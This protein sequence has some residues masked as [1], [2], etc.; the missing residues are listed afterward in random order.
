MND[1][2]TETD[3]VKKIVNQGNGELIDMKFCEIFDEYVSKNYP[4]TYYKI[5]WEKVKGNYKIFSWSH[6]DDVETEAFLKTTCIHNYDEICIIYGADEPALLVKREFAYKNLPNLTIFGWT[7]RYIV[8]VKRNQYGLIEIVPS[9]F[10]EVDFG[11]WL[12]ASC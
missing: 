1:F 4:W 10:I 2:I 7:T 8:A 5:D 12:T 3:T 9:C 6:A 11:D